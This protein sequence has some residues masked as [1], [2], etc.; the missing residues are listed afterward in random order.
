MPNEAR[1]SELLHQVDLAIEEAVKE[2]RERCA[3]VADEFG[4]Q[5]GNDSSGGMA[6]VIGQAIRALK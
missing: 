2:E 6:H 4:A 3:K 5:A 1:S